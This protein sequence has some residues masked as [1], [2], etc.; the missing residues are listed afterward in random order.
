MVLRTRR[1][2][3]NYR[4]PDLNCALGLS[5]LGKLDRFLSRRAALVA[6]YDHLL[7]PLRPRVLP[8]VRPVGG[9]PGW[10]LYA[11][12]IDFA[13]L[14]I[15]RADVMR[16][17][18]GAGIGTQV[19][20]VPV[21]SQPYYRRRYGDQTLPVAESYYRETLLLPLFPG[22]AQDVDRVVEILSGILDR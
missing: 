11:V 7:K 10:H 16:T 18:R 3:Y 4:L 15:A 20:Y 19:H 21:H 22:M 12:R 17:L 2:G 8:P 5:Q 14:G 13:A 9:E 6:R 1:A